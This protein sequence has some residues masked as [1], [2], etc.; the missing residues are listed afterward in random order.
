[1][2]HGLGEQTHPTSTAVSL[3]PLK[4]E[5]NE[6]GTEA[7]RFLVGEALAIKAEA[8]AE[9]EAEAAVSRSSQSSGRES[10]Q[11]MPMRRCWR[12]SASP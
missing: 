4:A 12:Y 3:R 2:E 10:V 5:V 11:A 9:A 7:S 1:M 6:S 8:E